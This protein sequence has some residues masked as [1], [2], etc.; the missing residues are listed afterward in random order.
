MKTQENAKQKTGE[1]V[2]IWK[3]VKNE[4]KSAKNAKKN[5]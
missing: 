3:N 4:K 2:K 5:L 1:N